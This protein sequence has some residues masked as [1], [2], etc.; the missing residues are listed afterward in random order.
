M[1][2]RQHEA[3]PKTP[4][5]REVYFCCY[6]AIVSAS[7]LSN[8]GVLA[9]NELLSG[10]TGGAHCYVRPPLTLIRLLSPPPP[11]TKAE[12]SSLPTLLAPCSS[13]L[14]YMSK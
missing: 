12:F 8:G 2:M 14:Q 7:V 1:A 9:G 4:Q 6:C 3:K 11:Q 10:S 5:L 13:G